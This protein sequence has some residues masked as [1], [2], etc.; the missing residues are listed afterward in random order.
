MKCII[1]TAFLL[2]PND[3]ELIH[4]SV[5]SIRELCYQ[6]KQLPEVVD[7]QQLHLL[8]ILMSNSD[9][10]PHPTLAS[11]LTLGLMPTQS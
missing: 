11:Q 1:V 7:S 3:V 9:K 6:I 4:S 5:L 2:G 10:K 8:R